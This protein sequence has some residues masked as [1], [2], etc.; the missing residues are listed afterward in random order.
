M[1]KYLLSLGLVAC[2]APCANAETILFSEN[3]DEDY[4]TSFPYI[5]DVDDLEPAT[6]VRALFLSTDGYYM[7]WWHLKDSSASTDRFIG[8]HSC[9]T[10]AGASNDWLGSRAIEIPTTG[11]K[12]TFGA[13]SYTFTKDENKLSDLW[14]FITEAPLDKN[15]LPTEPTQV[16]TKIPV[17]ASYDDLEGDFTNYEVDLSQYAGK[18]IF[19]N[20]ANL[21][22]SKD[23]LCLDNIKVSRYDIAEISV[24]DYDQYTLDDKYEISV[25]LANTSNIDL[26]NWEVSFTDANGT[27]TEDGEV[28]AAGASETFTFTSAIAPDQE[29]NFT[30]KLVG[31]N[32]EESTISGTISRLTHEPFRKVLVEESTG[33]W[34][35]WCPGGMHLVESMNADEEMSKYVI[36]V[37]V[38]VGNDN[39]SMPTYGVNLGAGSNAPLFYVNRTGVGG[40]SASYDYQFDKTRNGS[41]AKYVAD[42]HAKTVPLSIDVDG[43]W[44]INGADT[45]AIKCHAKVTPALSNKNAN[46]R[47]GFILTENN[48]GLDNSAYFVQLNN[49]SGGTDK[50]YVY[51]W[52]ELPEYL[53]NLRYN[54]VAREIDN[55][56]GLSGSLPYELKAD[57]E[58]T[59]DY[60]M[61]IPD[62]EII[63]ANTGEVAAK[64]IQRQFCT[65]IAFII[66]T[67]TNEIIN[68]NEY[69]MSDIAQ[70]RFTSKMY[71]EQ[72]LAA[73]VS[74]ITIDS[75]APATYYNLNGIRVD[76]TNLTPGIYI[77]HQGST[78]TKVVRK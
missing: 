64:A 66:D 38:H 1:N 55:F 57:Q 14:L 10:T 41:I 32:R 47:I 75:N 67:D 34:C 68:V 72:W 35:G 76:A 28:L 54:D 46:Y 40:P 12:L 60:T 27:Q 16:W 22:E 73:G 48:V 13:Q 56:K 69:P 65:L 50:N 2:L 62:A 43:E 19:L 37:S 5:Y 58:Y 52:S 39:L 17:G 61:E 74:D 36:P 18:T 45:T 25:N 21:N 7:P 53:T 20:F 30:V 51:P 15:N 9:Y 8:S 59:Y 4:S 3:F 29:M 33:M 24:L 70:D 44:V 23:I 26:V 78:T 71:Y 11:F 42:Q 31:D 49:L 63:V 6:T 77:R